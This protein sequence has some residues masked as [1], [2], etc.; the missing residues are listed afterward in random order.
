MTLPA[1]VKTFSIRYAGTIYHPVELA[2][3]EQ[4]RGFDQTA[5]SISEDGV[6][7]AGS[8]VWYPQ[9]GPKLVTFMLD[10]E[11]PAGWSAVSEGSGL[12]PEKK[13][14]PP[15]VRWDSP[16]PVDEIDLIA[17]RFTEYA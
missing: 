4:A 2:G 17:S 7:L 1:G 15:Q 10:V 3:K 11:L 14:D 13:Q 8:S 9:F 12:V 16:E 6:Y 5:G